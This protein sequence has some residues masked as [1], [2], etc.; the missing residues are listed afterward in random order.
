[1]FSDNLGLWSVVPVTQEEELLLRHDFYNI[2]LKYG[3]MV[4]GLYN[5]NEF[6]VYH[7]LHILNNHA[8]IEWN[9]LYHTG[10]YTPLYVKGV[11]EKSFL[12]CRDQTE[13]PKTMA[14]LIGGEL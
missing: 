13:I 3:P 10:M 6:V 7:A 5:K 2:F 11:G 14:R 12:E 8:S 4:D 9:S 1:V